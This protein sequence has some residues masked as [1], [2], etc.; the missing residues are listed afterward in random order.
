MTTHSNEPSPDSI[1]RDL[2]AIREQI[3]DEYGGDLVKL[4]EAARR[5]QELSGHEIIRKGE[6]PGQTRPGTGNDSVGHG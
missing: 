5:R 2:H 4:T 3:V 1:V 6:A